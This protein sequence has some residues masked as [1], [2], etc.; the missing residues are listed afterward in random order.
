M[1]KRAPRTLE[2]PYQPDSSHWFEKVRHLP[3][4]VF[5]QSADLNGVDIVSAAP[6]INVT[7]RGKITRIKDATECRESTQ[8]PFRILK[9]ILRDNSNEDLAGTEKPKFAGGALGY[10]SYDLGRR[11]ERLPGTPKADIRLPDMAVGIYR[12]SVETDHAERRT[13]IYFSAGCSELL[14]EQIEDC[15]GSEDKVAT[16]GFNLISSLVPNFSR[17]SYGDAFQR[18]KRYI[19]SGD[20]YQVNLAQRF[21]GTFCG[22]SWYLFSSLSKKIGAP[23]SAYMSSEHWSVL[24]FS[25]ERFL[26][27][28]NRTVMAQP[29]KGT[30][31]RSLNVAE[32]E[33]LAQELLNSD[34]DRAENLMIVD[35]LRNDLGKSCI[36]GTIHTPTLFRLERFKNVH[37][38]VSDIT[39][40][41]AD[42]KETTDLLR[43]C[44]PGGSITGAP[45]IR[46]M[47]IIDELEPQRRS[48]YCGCIGY[49]GFNGAM[50]MNIAIR[51]LIC[52]ADQIH[53]WGGGGIVADSDCQMEYEETFHKISNLLEAMERSIADQNTGTF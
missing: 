16:T 4:P 32:D 10:F 14:Q 39:G 42:T 22:D 18:I 24:S 48:V 31:P 7:T 34:K 25:P 38:L 8:D 17:E 49:L 1:R 37:H 23:F 43:G 46:A 27:V 12:W 19:N 3:D 30:R 9:R 21:S 53:C 33:R 35:L 11:I 44:F 5:L 51:T 20:C 15:L 41:L 6:D 28:N 45:K 36:P 29:I 26:S 50:D 13:R 52:D 47:Q 2:L 40:Q